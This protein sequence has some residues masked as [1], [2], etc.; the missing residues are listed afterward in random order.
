MRAIRR[1]YS[2]DG[3]PEHPRRRS[4][5]TGRAVVRRGR[6]SCKTVGESLTETGFFAVRNHGVP[7]ELTHACVRRSRKAFFH[8]PADVEGPLSRR[9]EEGPARLHRLR[10]GAREGLAGARPQGVLAG[11]PP[12]RAR[13]SPGASRCSVRTSGRPRSPTSGPTLVELYRH[14]ERSAASCCEAAAAYI[15][16][17]ARPV[18]R[19]DAPTA[20][21]SCAS[22]T[23][24]RSRRTSPIGAV[25]SAAHEDINL[26]TLLSGATAEGLE[27]K[28]HDG[29]W[30][31]IHTGFDTIVVDAGD[32][33]QNVTNGLYKSTTH[34]VV[35][36]RTRRASG[37]RSR[38]SCTRDATSI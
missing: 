9:R 38:A 34:R 8:L 37:S 32:M 29:T 22:S 10:H 36:P 20:T 17:P 31:P 1:R 11:R 35:N 6:P 2:S 5:A 3:S 33:L 25:R 27:L 24:R 19:D 16:E 18:P 26:I 23:T 4:R 12:R 15:D 21:R 14:L 7:D 13:R 30:M 28:R